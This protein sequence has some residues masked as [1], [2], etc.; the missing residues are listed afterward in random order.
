[1][2]VYLRPKV[3]DSVKIGDRNL[4]IDVR[5]VLILFEEPHHPRV[6]QRMLHVTFHIVWVLRI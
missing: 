1:M 3:L 6:L 4:I 2:D 5:L